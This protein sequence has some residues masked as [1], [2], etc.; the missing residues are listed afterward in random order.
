MLGDPTNSGALRLRAGRGRLVAGDEA[1]YQYLVESIRRFPPQGDFAE[2]V[3]R[4]GFAGVAYENLSG[5]VC[6]IHSGFKL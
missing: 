5:G 4:A 3:A 1:S 6:A 2:R